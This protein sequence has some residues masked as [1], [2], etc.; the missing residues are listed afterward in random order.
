ML[1]PSCKDYFSKISPEYCK[2]HVTY[3]HTYEE[4]DYTYFIEK[5]FK[6]K[7]KYVKSFLSLIYSSDEYS[8]SYIKMLPISYVE[9]LHSDHDYL[10][11]L[12]NYGDFID[13]N[14]FNVTKGRIGRHLEKV[15]IEK[16]RT[17]EDCQESFED[18]EEFL[19]DFEMA[20]TKEEKNMKREECEKQIIDLMIQ[21]RD[22]YKEY[23]PDGEYLTLTIMGDTLMAYN[24]A[25]ADDAD[26]PV[27]IYDDIK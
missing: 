12:A 27:D 17:S 19:K 5:N 11:S 8:G 4:M 20:M 16:L 24:M 18:D 9:N 1:M 7:G 3:S 22:V 10:V 26:H 25:Y 21:I 13:T 23:N 14:I 15:K 6:M 2:G